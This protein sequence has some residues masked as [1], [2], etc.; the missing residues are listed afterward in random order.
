MR[1]ERLSKFKHSPHQV[2]NPQPSGMYGVMY[3]NMAYKQT[4]SDRYYITV[5][6]LFYILYMSSPPHKDKFSA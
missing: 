1:P 2:S 3:K 5:K 4:A 6:I